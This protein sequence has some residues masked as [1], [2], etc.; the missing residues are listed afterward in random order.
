MKE[1]RWRLRM[2][3]RTDEP[4]DGR[5]LRRREWMRMKDERWPV[6]NMDE[7]RI[8]TDGRT[9]GLTDEQKDERL[10]RPW[11]WMRMKD[12][13]GAMKNM[14]KERRW[15]DGRVEGGTFVKAMGMDEVEG[16]TWSIEEHGWRKEMDGR[17]DW[18]TS[19]RTNACWG[20]GNGWGWQPAEKMNEEYGWR[21]NLRID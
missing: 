7:E 18:R 4:K 20:D 15:M 14:D 9:D 5:L 3:W 11:E 6:K 10:L 13:L 12:E 17:T 19:R 8:W 2:D 1:Y 16:W 21:S